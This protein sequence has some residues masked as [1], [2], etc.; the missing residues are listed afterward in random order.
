MLDAVVLR[1]P[2]PSADD[3]LIEIIF[4]GHNGTVANFANFANF[5]NELLPEFWCVLFFL[6]DLA[7]P[8]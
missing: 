1:L 6:H 5:F 7:S 2:D 3:V 8:N 4:P